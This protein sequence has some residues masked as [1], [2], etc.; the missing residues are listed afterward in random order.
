MEIF[1]LN[2]AF[3]LSSAKVIKLEDL[4]FVF[5]MYFRGL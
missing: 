4:R 3:N 5:F 2:T 1:A